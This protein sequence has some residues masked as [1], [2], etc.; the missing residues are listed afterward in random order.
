MILKHRH[1]NQIYLNMSLIFT[2]Y[3]DCSIRIF[4]ISMY[5]HNIQKKLEVISIFHDAYQNF[6]HMKE[7]TNKNL[8]DSL[9]KQHVFKEIYSDW[10]TYQNEKQLLR[11][12]ASHK[13]LKNKVMENV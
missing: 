8:L 11:E 10:C 7:N 13:N 9:C 6:H 12:I 5:N 1:D 4:S 2:A 3:N